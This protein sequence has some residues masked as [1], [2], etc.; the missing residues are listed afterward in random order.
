MIAEMSLKIC[1]VLDQ[2]KSILKM[3]DFGFVSSRMVPAPDGT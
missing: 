3:L 1:L 2:E